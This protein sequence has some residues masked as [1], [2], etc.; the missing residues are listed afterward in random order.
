MMLAVL[1]TA[2]SSTYV[3]LVWRAIFSNEVVEML[4]V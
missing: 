1:T 3:Q 4:D 2:A